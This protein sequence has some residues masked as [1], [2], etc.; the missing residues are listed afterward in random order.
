MGK[1][2]SVD[3]AILEELSNKLTLELTDVQEQYKDLHLRL[4]EL[5]LGAPY[6]YSHCFYSVGDPWGTGNKLVDKL[7]DLEVDLRRTASK[8]ADAENTIARLYKL[9]DKYG[10]LAAL[11][12]QTSHQLAYYGF[13]LTQFSK[14]A[15]DLYGFRHMNALTKLS[16]AI[17]NSRFKKY[18][19]GFLNPKYFRSKY[20]HIPFSDIVHK[21]IAKY[22]PDDTV[23]FSNSSQTFFKGAIRNNLNKGNVSSFIKTGAKFAKTNAISAVVV[24]GLVETGGMTLKISENYSKY[25]D[26]PDILKRENAKAVGNAVNN[27]IAVSAGSVGGAFVGG[28]VGSLLGPVGTVVGAAAGSFVGG[29]V[30]EQVGKLTAGFAEK[31]AIVFKEPIHKVTEFARGGFE[32]AGKVVESFNS[33]IEEVNKQIKETIKDPV[34]KVK[35]IGEN[36]GRGVSKVKKTAESLIDGAKNFVGKLSFG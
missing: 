20:N 34:K 9:Y 25:G 23:N 29:L 26:Q 15:D 27:T 17:D 16:D 32:K 33:G 36:V 13:G 28:A 22:L 4:S 8:F 7:S 19:R 12:T 31:A 35:E 3:P 6:E 5:I 24:T 30:G 1:G 18:A 11:G 2:I 14:S 21:K 10:T